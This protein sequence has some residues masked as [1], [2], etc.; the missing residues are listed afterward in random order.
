[1]TFE[2]QL[3]HGRVR[4]LIDSCRIRLVQA[5]VLARWPYATSDVANLEALI[6]NWCGPRLQVPVNLWPALHSVLDLTKHRVWGNEGQVIRRYQSKLT[7]LLKEDV[8]SRLARLGV[9]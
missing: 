4:D 7:K 2:I 3:E 6:R 1:M 8:V 9:A 5:N